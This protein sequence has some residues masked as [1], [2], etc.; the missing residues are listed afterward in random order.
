VNVIAFPGAADRQPPVD[1]RLTEEMAT[2]QYFAN[3]IISCV[4]EGIS[5]RHFLKEALAYID[6]QKP[7]T[8]FKS[9]IPTE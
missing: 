1:D 4:A 3:A 6:H 5:P 9:S 2:A 8:R 7:I